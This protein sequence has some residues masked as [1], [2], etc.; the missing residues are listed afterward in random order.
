MDER[1][2]P[3]PRHN[4]KERIS[5]IVVGVTEVIEDRSGDTPPTIDWAREGHS[6]GGE[7]RLAGIPG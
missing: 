1:A 2:K 6:A 5:R 3:T 7:R 4:Y